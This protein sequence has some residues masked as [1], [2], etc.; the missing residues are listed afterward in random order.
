ME[1]KFVENGTARKWLLCPHCNEEN[2]NYDV[3]IY[4]KCPFCN[5][6][7][8]KTNE[9]EDFILEPLVAQWEYQ[10]SMDINANFKAFHHGA[11]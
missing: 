10:C 11:H 9:L 1:Y 6:E 7:L 2:S 5:G 4:A 8:E 3:E